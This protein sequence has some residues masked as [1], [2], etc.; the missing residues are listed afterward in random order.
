MY[1][2]NGD[3]SRRPRSSKQLATVA[4]AIAVGIA[5]PLEAQQGSGRGFLFRQPV[6]TFSVR[7][8]FAQPNAGS[9]IFTF[10]TDELTLGRSDFAG[11]SVAADLSFRLRPRLDLVLGAAYSGSDAQS[12]F[13]DFV[14][15]NDLPIEQSTSLA[16]VPLTAS[17]KF[18]LASRGRSI[19]RY[20]WIPNKFAPFIGAGGGAMWYRF[21]QEGDFI[22]H[23]TFE[24]FDDTFRSEGWTPAW[25]GFAGVDVSLGPRFG[26]TGEARYTWAKA[27][28]DSDFSGFD[29]IDLSGYNASLG[30]YVRF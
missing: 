25:N 15:N 29:P 21:R 26:F 30:F 13:R 2:S 9:D 14:D 11:I 18:Y 8:G 17:A 12:E 3:G 27:T 28:L 1:A 10:V 6:G 23:D 16:R 24:V 20:A 22:D 4:L 7:A 19:G 5:A